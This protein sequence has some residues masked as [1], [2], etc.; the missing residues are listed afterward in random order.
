[1]GELEGKRLAAPADE[2]VG[3]GRELHV[4]LGGGERLLCRGVLENQLGAHLLLVERHRLQARK[5]LETNL[6][7]LVRPDYPSS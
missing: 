4:A 6:A 7:A 1:M 2:H 3:V 5:R